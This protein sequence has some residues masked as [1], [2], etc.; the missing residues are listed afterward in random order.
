MYI[1]DCVNQ[2][3]FLFH[4]NALLIQIILWQT[5]G[6]LY[7]WMDY[8]FDLLYSEF[9]LELVLK[10][11]LKDLKH[12]L[13]VAQLKCDKFT[14]RHLFSHLLKIVQWWQLSLTLNKFWCTK[15][16]WMIKANCCSLIKGTQRKTG[17]YGKKRVN[18]S[19][20]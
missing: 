4:W 12:V 3:E 9:L 8:T 10:L 2:I 1:Y 15:I 13:F 19:Q 5:T 20:P 11:Y 17:G 7:I 16:F 14:A 6:I 18:I